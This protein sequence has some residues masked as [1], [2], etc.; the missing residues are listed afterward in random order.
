MLL[1][2]IKFRKSIITGKFAND[3]SEVGK[4]CNEHA[5][6]KTIPSHN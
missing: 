5:N 6:L 1:C 3:L 4:N 2:F